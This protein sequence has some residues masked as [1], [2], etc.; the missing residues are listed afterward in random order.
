MRSETK[1]AKVYLIPHN[2]RSEGEKEG[3]RASKLRTEQAVREGEVVYHFI[4]RGRKH[5]LTDNSAGRSAVLTRFSFIH[6][7]TYFPLP[8][9]KNN[10]RRAANAPYLSLLLHCDLL[11]FSYYVFFHHVISFS[12][13]MAEPRLT[14]P[15]LTFSPILPYL[16]VIAL[17]SVALPMTFTSS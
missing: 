15:I 12:Q 7:P 17:L 9:E 2:R 11:L 13:P 5:E 4:Y 16:F 6:N 8:L 3:E 14:L 1:G 10:T